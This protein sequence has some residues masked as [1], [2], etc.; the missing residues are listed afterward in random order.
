MIAR[1]R[2]AVG[3]LGVLGAALGLLALFAAA[4][5]SARAAGD[6]RITDYASRI[7]IHADGSMTVTETIDVIATGQAIRHGIYRDFPTVYRDPLGN[8]LRVGFAVRA[9]E[10]DGR[11]EPFFVKK[12][13]NGWRVYMGRKDATIPPGP[14]S[15]R[16]VYATDLQIGY[17]EDYDELYWN[18]IGTGWTFPIDRARATVLL[19]GNA[20]VIT[21]LAFTGPEG[22][23]AHD[24]ITEY[25]ADGNPV[26]IT[27]RPLAPH[28]G[29]TVAV[30][31]PKG[32]V[33]EP[34]ASRRVAAYVND[35]AP[36][37][38][39]IAGLVVLFGYFAVVWA[40]VG[41]DPRKG[42]IVPLFSPPDG[43]SPAA[44]RLVMRMGFDERAFAAA[45]L[46]MAVKGYLTIREEADGGFLLER[47]GAPAK[48]LAPGERRV[49]AKLFAQ[50]TTLALDRKNHRTIAAAIKA[51]RESLREDFERI[52]YRCNRTYLI[53]GA[54][55]TI[56]TLGVLVMLSPRPS[57]ASFMLLWLGVW[58]LGCLMLV[59]QIL[60]AWRSRNRSATAFNIVFALP[61]LGGELFGAWALSGL[62]TPPIVVLLIVLILVNALFYELLKAPTTMGRR[63]MDRIEGF[64]M[65]LSTAEKDRLD[66]LNPPEKTPALFEKYLPYALALDVETEW[67]EQ[68]AGALGKAAEAP[69][70]PRWYH[71]RSWSGAGGLTGFAEGLGGN[72]VGAVAASAT[73]PGSAS[74]T[75]GG[76]SGGGGGGG[77]G[78]G[79]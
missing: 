73:A 29:L 17:F 5:S 11:P 56:L 51:L 36:L 7:E 48:R 42:T 60:R 41:R 22:S 9:V 71:G 74:G 23:R 65:Y 37:F 15:Y 46:D 68:F 3:V 76:S 72:F 2:R 52:H 63:V 43:F 35:N 40:M 44:T 4:P 53:P 45:I 33:T 8:R 55:L 61:F 79:W 25:D 13:S 66:R 1:A 64:R 59:R 49:A 50:G 19:P 28:E 6:E 31:W 67:S 47:T 77:G 14:H 12:L 27:T 24:A 75:G 78:G 62:V 54:L 20:P 57:E 34:S 38:V 18:A 69:Y 16:L 10:R 21:A 26:F 58:T 32:Y 39:G 70:A 30:S